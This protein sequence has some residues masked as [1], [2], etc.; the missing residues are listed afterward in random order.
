MVL[1][2]CDSNLKELLEGEFHTGIDLVTS[3]RSSP[4]SEIR[5]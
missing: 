1:M 4:F 2:D 3:G 5:S